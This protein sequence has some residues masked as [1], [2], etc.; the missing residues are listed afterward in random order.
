MFLGTKRK[1]SPSEMHTLHIYA[2]SILM[3]F[4]TRTINLKRVNK[5]YQK[6]SE[7]LEKA[8][9]LEEVNVF[10]GKIK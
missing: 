4:R 5:K 7:N 10:L 3:M 9:A 1:V 8:K 6:K 2:L